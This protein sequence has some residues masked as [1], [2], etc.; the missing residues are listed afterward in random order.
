MALLLLSPWHA[1]DKASMGDEWGVERIE[2]SEAASNEDLLSL[3]GAGAATTCGVLVESGAFGLC[4]TTP[5]APHAKP[6][7]MTV[8]IIHQPA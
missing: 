8:E 3:G 5:C 4:Q 1:Q 2:S 7:M 6:Y